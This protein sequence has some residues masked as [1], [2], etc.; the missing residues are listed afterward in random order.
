[1]EPDGFKSDRQ[2]R[3][4]SG[5]STLE[6]IPNGG[7]IQIAI[8]KDSN[9]GGLVKLDGQTNGRC[10]QMG[11]G[12]IGARRDMMGFLVTLMIGGMIG[13]RRRIEADQPV[14]GTNDEGNPVRARL[15]R[16]RRGHPALR[17]EGAQ[18]HRHKGDVQAG[19]TYLFSGSRHR[20][21]DNDGYRRRLVRSSRPL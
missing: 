2:K 20:H 10:R 5:F 21:I 3:G 8:H 1:M 13:V 18:K 7:N 6:D 15:V 14:A 12:G 4:C 17:Q 11:G 9:K 19:Q 16:R